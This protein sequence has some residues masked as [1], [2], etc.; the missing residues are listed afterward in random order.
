MSGGLK[1]GLM[2]PVFSN[3]ADRVRSFA[4]NAAELGFD[5]VFAADHLH[6]P[7]SP[8]RPVFEAFAVLA[9]VAAENPSLTVGTLVARVGVRHPSML[10]KMAAAT[11]DL[12]MSGFILGLGSG[13]EESDEEDAAAGLPPVADR[14]ALLSETVGALKDL[15]TGR[16]WEGGEHTPEIPGPLLPPP[17][18]P[19]GPPIWIG[20]AADELVRMAARQA[21]GWNG[22]G[23]DPDRFAMKAA[24]LT[25]AADGRPVEATWGG[26]VA[27]G[28]DVKEA[29]ALAETRRMKELPPVWTGSVEQLRSWAARMREGGATWFICGPVMGDDRMSLIAA[30]LEGLR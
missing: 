17:S 14:R 9:T 29:E 25:D 5:G 21:D 1:I 16:G 26:L 18:R 3:D 20:G 13:D 11:D 2:L 23:M 19:G 4:R 22:W 27:V 6:L 8:K 24:M 7:G 28:E 30:A 15:F 12:A 10:A